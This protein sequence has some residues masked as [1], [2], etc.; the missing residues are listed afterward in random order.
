MLIKE[1]CLWEACEGSAHKEQGGKYG[2][3]KSC[4]PPQRHPETEQHCFFLIT[5][6]EQRV[7]NKPFFSLVFVF[8]N[9]S[10]LLLLLSSRCL[11]AYSEM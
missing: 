11:F 4:I 2:A 7:E 5:K 3:E 9:F 6:N 1:L 10:L 8:L